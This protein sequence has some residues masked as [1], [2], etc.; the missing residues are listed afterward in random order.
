M[1]ARGYADERMCRREDT[2]TRE[3]SLADQRPSF[4]QARKPPLAHSAGAFARREA[5]DRKKACRREDML[6]RGYENERSYARDHRKIAALAAIAPKA[7]APSVS[8]YFL[9]GTT[10]RSGLKCRWPSR[11]W[12][13]A[14]EWQ[15][16]RHWAYK[17]E[18]QAR[19]WREPGERPCKDDLV[20]QSAVVVR[21]G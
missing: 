19:G 12:A 11:H 20:P 5:E 6:T 3:A 17:R 16:L 9:C 8:S 2:Q 7:V 15:A 18:W 21:A 13:Y 1:H 14:R 4:E 10:R